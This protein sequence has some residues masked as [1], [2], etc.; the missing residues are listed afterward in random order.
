MCSHILSDQFHWRPMGKY[1]FK[2]P[3]HSVQAKSSP[4]ELTAL[5]ASQFKDVSRTLFFWR[6]QK[7]Y[8]QPAGAEMA[9]LI[10][11][12]LPTRR[13]G[14]ILIQLSLHNNTFSPNSW[15]FQNSELPSSHSTY[16]G[17]PVY[18]FY[19]LARILGHQIKLDQVIILKVNTILVG[20]TATCDSTFYC[21]R[22]RQN[23]GCKQQDGHY[24]LTA[25]CTHQL[26]A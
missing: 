5:V 21:F 11:L 13:L 24:Y 14:T 12:L 3:L 4:K 1:P 18:S 2:I 6:S 15:H 8:T 16:S 10:L 23:L 22:E 7:V 17:T 26:K 20:K 19:L 25:W 9:K